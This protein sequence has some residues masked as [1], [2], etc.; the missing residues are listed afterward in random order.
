MYECTALMGFSIRKSSS[1]VCGDG[2]VVLFL[3]NIGP[4]RQW[5]GIDRYELPKIFDST[6][7]KPYNSISVIYNFLNHIVKSPFLGD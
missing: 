7:G 5:L 3:N 2:S 4:S 1:K 6:K